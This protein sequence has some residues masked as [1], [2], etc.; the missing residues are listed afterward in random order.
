MALQKETWRQATGIPP[1]KRLLDLSLIV[2]LC[3][4]ALVLGGLVAAVVKLGSPGPVLFRQKRVGYRGK[5][6]MCL[7]FRTMLTDA[8]IESHR[9][10]TETLIRSKAPMTKLDARRDPR[11]APLGSVLRA[12][13][14]DELPQLINILR[15]EMSLVGPRPCIPYE[16][17]LYETSQRRRFNAAPG[18]TGLWQ[19]SG[20]NRTTFEEMVRLDIKYSETLSPWLDIKIILKTLPAI[21]G[22][23]CELRDVKSEEE[24]ISGRELGK[25]VQSY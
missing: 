17:E 9:R 3:P 10:H 14:L 18:L 7:K 8:D 25:S 15:A 23:Y 4:G 6:F 19:V 11:L 20:K 16:Y 22:Q 2:I 12:T 13:G 1:W 5:Q 24:V 21:W